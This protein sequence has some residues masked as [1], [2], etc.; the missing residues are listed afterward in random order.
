MW[1]WNLSAAGNRL[2]LGIDIGSTTT[3]YAVLD[4][5]THDVMHLEY[6]RHGA[7]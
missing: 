7:H 3:K 1:G 6:R 4:A 5:S 2:H